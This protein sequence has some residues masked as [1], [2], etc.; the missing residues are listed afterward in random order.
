MGL[1]V[2]SSMKNYNL[3]LIFV[4]MLS[5]SISPATDQRLRKFGTKSTLRRV[6][7][8][9]ILLG[10]GLLALG[11]FNLTKSQK[12]KTSHDQVILNGNTGNTGTTTGTNGGQNQA[13][14]TQGYEVRIQLLTAYYNSEGD[15][16]NT[17]VQIKP[18][19]DFYLTVNNGPAIHDSV[20]INQGYRP[21]YI[22]NTQ[23]LNLLRQGAPL[24]IC[25]KGSSFNGC[26]FVDHPTCGNVNF[27]FPFDRQLI[28]PG[29]V[30]ELKILA[31]IKCNLYAYVKQPRKL[32]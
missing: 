15:L 18:Q 12:S 4:K 21:V 6:K 26:N 30:S 7:K 19:D 23:A 10:I 24:R 13:Q 20:P 5:L 8:V 3:K 16:H 9:L 25:Y 31:D 28:K 32:A 11:A 17:K 29:A 1:L 22:K 27:Y 14:N 2:D